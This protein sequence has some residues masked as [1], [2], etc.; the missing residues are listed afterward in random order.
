M[1]ERHLWENRK[2]FLTLEALVQMSKE[3]CLALAMEDALT[4]PD[5]AVRS[6]RPAIQASADFSGSFYHLYCVLSSERN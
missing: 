5:M 6:P 3:L 1:F 2:R 4:S